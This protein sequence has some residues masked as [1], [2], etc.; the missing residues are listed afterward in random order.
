M[1]T[2]L[3]LIFLERLEKSFLANAMGDLALAKLPYIGRLVLLHRIWQLPMQ[4]IGKLSSRMW[5]PLRSSNPLKS[6]VFFYLFS[7]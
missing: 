1:A 3:R 4:F 6:P 5:V 7:Y 2:L